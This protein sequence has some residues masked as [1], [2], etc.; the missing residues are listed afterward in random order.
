MPSQRGRELDAQIPADQKRTI[1]RAE[2]PIGAGVLIAVIIGIQLALPRDVTVGPKWLV[3]GLELAGALVLGPVLIFTAL[4]GRVRRA[5]ATSYLALLI[6]ASV[7]NGVL[8]L[9]SLLDFS[10]HPQTENGDV[11]LFAGFGV[12]V[13]NVL[14]FALVYWE[15]DGGGPAARSLGTHPPDFLFPQQADEDATWQ[16]TLFD[17]TFTAY[18]NIIAFSPTDT[19]PLT[20]RVK[21]LFMVQSSV[22]LVTILV[23]MSRAINLLT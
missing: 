12:L 17:Y 15:L 10:P 7:L 9:F 18:T 16:P 11:L 2:L 8:L 19:M 23:T 1:K 5:V 3:P 4:T 6:C 21:A 22:S 14:S 20:H 13:I